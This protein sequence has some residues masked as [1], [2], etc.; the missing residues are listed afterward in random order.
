MPTLEKITISDY[1]NI[2][3]QEICFS[4]NVNCIWGD[5]GEGKTNL[6]DAIYYLSMTK[7]AM[8]P[9]DRYNFRHGCSRF[10]ICGQFRMPNGLSKRIS[11]EVD[12]DGKKIRHDEKICR[13][14][15]HIGQLPV[16]MVSP[17]DISLVSESSEERR[18][19]LNGVLSQLDR[20]YLESLQQYN[21]LLAQRNR[22]LKEERIDGAL[23]KVLDERMAACAAPVYKARKE[24]A[25]RLEDAVGRLY[26]DISGGTEEVGIAYSS[27]LDDGTLDEILCRRMDRDLAQ[28]FTT[29]GIQRDELIFN[30]DGHPIRRCGSQGQQKSFLV[31]LK[32]AQYSLMDARSGVKPILLLDDLL[33][34][35]D[36]QR[37][38]HLLDMV[39]GQEFGQIFI[40][41]SD[42]QRTAAAIDSCT[43]ERAYFKAEGGVFTRIDG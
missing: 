22:L 9:S 29:A 14:L 19:F 34:K 18:K 23:L 36:M 41:D 7:S 28:H 8:S 2:E 6:L 13:T 11:V 17:S 39:S 35:L 21:R 30:L 38:S 26:R 5:N 10:A 33:D 42:R 1:R 37:A 27:D 4:P 31:A 40:S 16:V 32:F 24:F 20:S 43:T 3:M 12:A 15:D 25:A